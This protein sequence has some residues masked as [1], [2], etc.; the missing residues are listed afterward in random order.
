M[1]AWAHSVWL[2]WCKARKVEKPVAEMSLEELDEH[3]SQFVFETRRQDGNPYPPKTL[4]QLVCGLQRFLRENGRP[5]VAMFDEKNPTFDKSR[6][7]LDAR[8]KQLMSQGVGTATKSA[9]PLT[10]EQEIILWDKDLFSVLSAEG[11]INA[12]FLV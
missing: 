4:Y 12:V 1:T 5:E 3:L 7:V 6:K 8:M 2:A 9:E 11:L 10:A